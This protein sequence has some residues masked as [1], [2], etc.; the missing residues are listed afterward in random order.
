MTSLLPSR[1]SRSARPARGFTLIEVMVVV[2]I[3]GILATV[4]L[5]QMQ[6]FTLRTKR[7]ERELMVRSIVRS[8]Q[9]LRQQESRGITGMTLQQNPASA[10]TTGRAV[11]NPKLAS[12]DASTAGWDT[13][14]FVPTS[15]LYLRYSGTATFPEGGGGSFTLLV[16]GD[17][18]SD[19]QVSTARYDFTWQ[20]D[21][22]VQTSEP[23]LL[24]DDW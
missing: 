10:A 11:F 21:V 4:A 2:A 18:D 17:L 19:G 24:G 23:V 14:G 16:D 8:V 12:G 22:W 13:L 7:A 3:L 1:P 20:D 9:Q 5:P 15:S 6:R